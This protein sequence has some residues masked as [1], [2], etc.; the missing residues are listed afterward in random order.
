[1]SV[2]I[3]FKP[4]ERDGLVAEGTYLW[5]A[6]K[7]M[8]IYLA[9]ECEGRGEC[10]TCAVKIE[11][12][13]DLLSTPTKAEINMLSEERRTNGE[14]LACQTKI[15]RSGEVVVMATPPKEEPK[16]EKPK[17][18]QEEFEDLPFEKKFST[19]AK[20]EAI[21]LRETVSFILNLPFTASGKVID[22]MAGFGWEMDKQKHTEK[23]PSEHQEEAQENKDAKAETNGEVKESGEAPKKRTRRKTKE[24]EN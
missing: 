21:A 5:D 9:A 12:G 19:L 3:K 4:S 6:A 8:G 18:W 23:R 20:L 7:R 10:D 1:M 16:E 22:I 17:D 24:T 11:K 2:E 15:E 14:R 13:A